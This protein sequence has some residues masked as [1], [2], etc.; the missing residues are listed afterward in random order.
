M[1]LTGW[2]CINRGSADPQFL[3][4]KYGLTESF[5][6]VS[7]PEGSGQKA[8]LII[9]RHASEYHVYLRDEAGLSP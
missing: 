5:D 2:S 4:S 1:A 3:Q 7:T 6:R 8:Q 9:P